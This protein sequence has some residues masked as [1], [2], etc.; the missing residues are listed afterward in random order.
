MWKLGHRQA[1]HSAS[2]VLYHD[3][4]HARC[5]LRGLIFDRDRPANSQRCPKFVHTNKHRD[6]GCVNTST[7]TVW[8]PYLRIW[9]R[10]LTDARRNTLKKSKAKIHRERGTWYEFPP[11]GSWARR[12]KDPKEK[13]I[14]KKIKAKI[15]RER[16]T[17]YEFPTWGIWMETERFPTE[18]KNVGKCLPNPLVKC[19]GSISALRKP[20][21]FQ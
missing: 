8:V 13:H 7:Y 2:L 14:Q 4:L 17:L 21:W 3:K 20:G 1:K 10:R 9:T 11:W 5:S 19:V 6:L 18:G 12:L 15:Y 16:G